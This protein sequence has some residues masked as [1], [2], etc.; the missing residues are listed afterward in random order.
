[1]SEYSEFSHLWNTEG[2]V[3]PPSKAPAVLPMDDPLSKFFTERAKGNAAA[4]VMN[5]AFM[6]DVLGPTPP[7]EKC[8]PQGHPAVAELNKLFNSESVLNSQLE[9]MRKSGT[10]GMWAYGQVEKAGSI[11]EG[12]KNATE[13]FLEKATIEQRILLDKAIAALDLGAW[14]EVFTQI[15]AKA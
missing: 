7:P 3:T 10:A 2:Y 9:A 13:L 11:E 12:I 15:F 1:M 4:R 5:D 14:F 6:A 8:F